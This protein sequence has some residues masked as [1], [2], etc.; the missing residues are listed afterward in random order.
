MTKI[1]QFLLVIVLLCSVGLAH[2]QQVPKDGAVLSMEQSTLKVTPGSQIE[3]DV[4]LLRSKKYKKAK[5]GGLTARSPQGMEIDFKQDAQ[6]ADL[7]KMIV[8]V[9][10]D[11]QIKPYTVVVKGMGNNAQKIK[12]LAVSIDLGNGQLVESNK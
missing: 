5:F 1:T 3:A 12:G 9:S 2:A 6:N 10:Q 4:T 8:K 7:Y 11:V